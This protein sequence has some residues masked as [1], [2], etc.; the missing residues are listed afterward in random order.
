[1]TGL[2][3]YKWKVFEGKVKTEKEI[4]KDEYDI[5]IMS[6]KDFA[7]VCKL[8]TRQ[9]TQD[10]EPTPRCI[11]WKDWPIRRFTPS[12]KSSWQICPKSKLRML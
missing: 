2:P 6:V 11:K 10:R 7:V 3:K 8:G 12:R 9:V 4:A 1:M 5:I